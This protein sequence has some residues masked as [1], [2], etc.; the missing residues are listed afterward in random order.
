M[1]KRVRYPKLF[2]PFSLTYQPEHKVKAEMALGKLL[3]LKA[4]V[5]HHSDTE[6]VICEDRFYHKLLHARTN[7]ILACG[8]AN[9]RKCTYCKEYDSLKNLEHKFNYYHKSCVAQYRHKQR[10]KKKGGDNTCQKGSVS[11]MAELVSPLHMRA[12]G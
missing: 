1:P 2:S 9:W 5:H 10:E 11:N 4:E 6:L 8:N 3:P 12:F 7:A